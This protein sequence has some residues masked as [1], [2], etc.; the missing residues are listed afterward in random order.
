MECRTSNT[1]INILTV[2]MLTWL[3]L[4]IAWHCPSQSVNVWGW[5]TLWVW[6]A[7]PWLAA[8]HS[9]LVQEETELLRGWVKGEIT[10]QFLLWAQETQCAGRLTMSLLQGA[11]EPPSL[12]LLVLI[13]AP[14]QVLEC[15]QSNVEIIVGSRSA[16]SSLSPETPLE[17]LCTDVVPQT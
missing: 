16:F 14:W 13:C 15:K 1:S 12:R 11:H 4:E 9:L 17:A 8:W 5:M 10:N 7:D 6:W 2:K 3:H